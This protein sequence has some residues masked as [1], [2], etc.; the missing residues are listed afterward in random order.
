MH[1]F[2]DYHVQHSWK[3][4]GSI[5]DIILVNIRFPIL[6]AIKVRV[7]LF[8][9]MLMQSIQPALLTRQRG[10]IKIKRT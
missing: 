5:V 10:E 2:P 6:T 9:K 8:A 1:D 7:L 4:I 3:P